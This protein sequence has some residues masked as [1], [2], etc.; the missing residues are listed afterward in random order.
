M[1]VDRTEEF[2]N[3]CTVLLKSENINERYS[4]SDH[5]PE[6]TLVITAKQMRITILQTKSLILKN[7]YKYLDM[8]D[9]IDNDNITEN[10][11]KWTDDDRFRFENKVLIFVKD[12]TQQ[13]QSLQ[14]A[15]GIIY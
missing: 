11:T 14:Q 3:Y 9:T 10:K 15:L 5:I 1:S 13:I 12:I 4:E 7:Q 6:S 2:K 8:D